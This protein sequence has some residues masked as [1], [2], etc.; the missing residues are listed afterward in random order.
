MPL[1]D[2]PTDFEG[3]S[4]PY[5]DPPAE[6]IKRPPSSNAATGASAA[7]VRALS[8]QLVA[9][10]FRAPVKAFFRTRV[11]YLAYAKAI[12]PHLEVQQGWSWRTTTAGLLA[13]AIRQDG[14]GFIPRQVLPPLFANVGI[15]AI[16]YTTYLQMLG[17]LHKPSAEPAKRVFPPP[18]PSATLA[19]GLVAGSV[20]SF[21]AA[22]LDA[23]SVRFQKE[24]IVKGEYRN[25]WTYG[26]HKLREIG[27]RGIFAGWSL[28]FVKDSLGSG[29]FFATFEYVKAQAYY[30]FITQWYSSKARSTSKPQAKDL[31]RDFQ[32]GKDQIVIL[33]P[34]YAL[35]PMFL[36][37]AGASASISQQVIQ[38]PMTSFQTLHYE[39]LESID[40]AAQAARSR[41]EILHNYMR[42]YE[43]TW[44]LCK[45]DAGVKNARGPKAGVVLGH[46][47]FMPFAHIRREDYLSSMK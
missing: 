5:Q 3:I 41:R 42:A 40:L 20:Q 7:G 34:H 31:S 26:K 19:A 13:H 43:Q 36:L 12:N 30:K 47:G 1:D 37:L 22:P 23:L 33:K 39:R 14:L 17:Q 4:S 32:S 8:T 46:E 27:I 10:Y 25:M 2:D 15:G 6:V 21:V 9:F 11:D 44:K 38:H 35:E 18:P 24:E 16:L 45:A 28:S 29:V